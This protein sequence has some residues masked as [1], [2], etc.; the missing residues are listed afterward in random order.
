MDIFT[1]RLDATRSKDWF[2]V[3]A[4]PC[5]WKVNLAVSAPAI[6]RLQEANS[7]KD[8]MRSSHSPG[9]NGTARGSKHEREDGAK[10]RLHQSLRF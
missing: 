9:M 1:Q 6:K 8:L 3:T 10:S 2:P 7:T 5:E 4:R